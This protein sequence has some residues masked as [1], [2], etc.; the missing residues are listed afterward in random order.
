MTYTVLTECERHLFAITSDLDPDRTELTEDLSDCN[1]KR[2]IGLGLKKTSK[3]VSA[4][5]K[6][7]CD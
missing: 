6:A 7:K 5:A 3:D 1:F 2:L 4:K